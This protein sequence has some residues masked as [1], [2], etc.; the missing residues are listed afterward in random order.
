MYRPVPGSLCHGTKYRRFPGDKP[1]GAGPCPGRLPGSC[2][3]AAGAVG[4]RRH[5]REPNIACRY[6]SWDEYFL[7]GST[8]AS[9]QI[10]SEIRR[11]SMSPRLADANLLRGGIGMNRF[12]A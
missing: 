4:E 9:A 12:D 2:D 11:P 5:G 6:E 8:T 10:R 7:S 1:G 3:D